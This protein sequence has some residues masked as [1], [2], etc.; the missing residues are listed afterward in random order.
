MMAV[1]MIAMP[2]PTGTEAQAEEQPIYPA[3]DNQNYY[4]LSDIDLGIIRQ[5]WNCANQPTGEWDGFDNFYAYR[6][7]L[8]FMSYAAALMQQRLPAYRQ[9]LQDTQNGL[10]RK[11]IEPEVGTTG[12]TSRGGLEAKA[13]PTPSVMRTSCTPD[14]LET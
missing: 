6:Y 5:W 10:V 11:M 1:L 9:A 4:E 3:S 13:V 7:E 2:L 12:K 8:G 14:I